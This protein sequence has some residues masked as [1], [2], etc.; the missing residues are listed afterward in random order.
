MIV[1]EKYIQEDHQS[2]ADF[3]M[4]TEG[5]SKTM[6]GQFFGQQDQLSQS[7][8][9][10]YCALLDFREMLIDDALRLLLERFRLPGE[11]Q[12]IDRII[13]TFAHV[14]YQDNPLAF[15]SEDTTYILAYSAIMLN[16]DLHNSFAETSKKMTKSQFT[17]NNMQICKS[18]R[19][20]FLEQMYDRIAKQQFQCKADYIETLYNRL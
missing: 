14:Y 9:K 13:V 18:L 15:D 8:L 3:L 2:I 19:K 20:E 16:T 11:A 12:Q 17:K 4:K 10:Q 7:I 1:N 6:L 5:I